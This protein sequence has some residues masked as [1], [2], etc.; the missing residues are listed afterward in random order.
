MHNIIQDKIGRSS[1]NRMLGK[2]EVERG[3]DVITRGIVGR[4]V[5][6]REGSLTSR[7]PRSPRPVVNPFQVDFRP[8]MPTDKAG[9]KYV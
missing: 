5:L 4:L 1:L 9:R 2:T 7:H 3:R 8:E 6:E